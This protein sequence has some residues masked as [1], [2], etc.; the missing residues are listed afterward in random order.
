MNPTTIKILIGAGSAAV[1]AIT[2][3]FA[4]RAVY[5]KKMEETIAAE[6]AQFKKDYNRRKFGTTPPK[7]DISKLN[8]NNDPVVVLDAEKFERMNRQ[9][10]KLIMENGYS[11]ITGSVADFLV[12][13][14]GE[15]EG[16]DDPFEEEPEDHLEVP[17]RVTVTNGVVEPFVID[18][19]E[20]DGSPEGTD[21]SSL[22]YYEVD[23]VL[24]DEDG[25]AISNIN[26][27]IGFDSLDSFGQG[28]HDPNIVYVRNPKTKVDY[29]VFRNKGSYAEEV[30][31]IRPVRGSHR[32]MRS[33]D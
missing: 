30:H 2:T 28:S 22:I 8:V 26:E 31:G 17:H 13:D 20:W 10:A 1:S 12:E 9:V 14:D 4:T 11:G 21:Q 27:V 15:S 19:E 6:V 32:K 24:A 33:D 16:E 23:E 5:K 18:R 3:F 25:S 7:P 29:E